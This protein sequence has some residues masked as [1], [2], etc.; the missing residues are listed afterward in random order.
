[1]DAD[2][3]AGSALIA[4]LCR[5]NRVAD[6]ETVYNDMLACAWR[7]EHAALPAPAARRAGLSH[8]AHLP[9]GEALAAL[10]LAAAQ[11]KDLRAAAKYYKQL[12]R[13]GPAELA[14]VAAS[15][16]RMWEA[17]IETCCRAN[18]VKQALQV[19][20][21]RKGSLRGRGRKGPCI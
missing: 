16:R 21:P 20:G 5:A 13:V 18:K 2:G 14:A 7:R 1:M 12:R 3:P 15:H 19:I 8:R 4:S 6:A 17:L 10:V 11:A 9:D